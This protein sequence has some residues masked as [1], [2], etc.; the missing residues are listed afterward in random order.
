MASFE[1][2]K[3][4]EIIHCFESPLLLPVDS[5]RLQALTLE[6]STARELDLVHY[7]V[8]P[9]PVADPVRITG[10]DQ[11]CDSTLN[12]AGKLWEE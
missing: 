8:V 2:S 11:H 10:P 5:I 7:F 9:H 3:E 12:H 4:R 1:N 6:V